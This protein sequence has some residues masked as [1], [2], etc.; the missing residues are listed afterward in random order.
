[1][2]ISDLKKKIETM[3]INSKKGKD[4][5]RTLKLKQNNRVRTYENNTL[6]KHREKLIGT[7]CNKKL[8]VWRQLKNLGKD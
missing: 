2:D 5:L 8:S 7:V 6:P 1:M 4:N 3:T